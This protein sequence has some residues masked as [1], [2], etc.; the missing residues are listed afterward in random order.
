MI[1]GL[2]ILSFIAFIC[3][4]GVILDVWNSKKKV[5]IKVIWSLFAIF[6]NILTAIIYIILREK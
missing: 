6:F 4:I 1:F 5:W 3:A 2:E